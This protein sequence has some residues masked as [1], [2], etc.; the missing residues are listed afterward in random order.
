MQELDRVVTDPRLRVDDLRRFADEGEPGESFLGAYR[1]FA[2]SGATG[3]PG[4]FVYREDEFAH[5][6]AAGL[7]R[8]AR[9]GI[10]ADTKLVAVGAPGDVHITRQ[11]FAA[12]QC[13]RTGVPRLSATTP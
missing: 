8:L 9:V 1:V 4:L 11:L 7:A 2:T 12:F 3:I 10:T 13:G 6:I 5:W